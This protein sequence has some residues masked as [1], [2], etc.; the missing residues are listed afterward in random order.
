MGG[1]LGD[2]VDSLTGDA[3]EASDSLLNTAHGMRTTVA[4]FTVLGL[5]VAAGLALLITRV[6]SVRSR[7]R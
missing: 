3:N 1:V 6:W 7:R 2:T 4:I 5:V